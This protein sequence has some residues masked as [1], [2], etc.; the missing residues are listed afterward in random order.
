MLQT[1]SL[2]YSDFID[3]ALDVIARFYKLIIPFSSHYT[4]IWELFWF[5]KTL[6]GNCKNQI[7]VKVG[8]NTGRIFS[9]VK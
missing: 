5:K 2:V 8:N 3:D 9:V 7:I 4:A 6:Y 1:E